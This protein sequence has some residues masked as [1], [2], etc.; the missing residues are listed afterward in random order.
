M[1]A[2]K[3]AADR[4]SIL[5]ACADAFAS[6]QTQIEEGY[7]PYEDPDLEGVDFSRFNTISAPTPAVRR[8]AR[9]TAREL[10]ETHEQMCFWPPR[11]QNIGLFWQAVEG[12]ERIPSALGWALA[13][14]EIQSYN[15]PI[16]TSDEQRLLD[17]LIPLFTDVMVSDHGQKPD[18]VVWLPSNPFEVIELR[19]G[20]LTTTG[21]IE[22]L[23][24]HSL[25]LIVGGEN[26]DLAPIYMGMLLA[27]I[28]EALPKGSRLKVDGITVY[29]GDDSYAAIKQR[30]FRNQP[31]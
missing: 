23:T 5:A 6:L 29:A 27:R 20:E 15:S 16:L 11:A 8:W 26:N 24:G 28:E 1:S 9:R 19:S 31:R 14:N 10:I 17:E 21:T 7:D 30:Y 18:L 3:I 22:L 4:R 2:Q 12:R 25:D 13:I